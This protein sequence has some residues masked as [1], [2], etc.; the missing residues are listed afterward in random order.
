LV[1]GHVRL[2]TAIG[3][4]ALTNFL[5]ALPTVAA[6]IQSW[7]CGVNVRS[8]VWIEPLVAQ[9]LAY[10]R[11]SIPGQ[12]SSRPRVSGCLDGVL[13]NNV[14]LVVARVPFE[15]LGHVLEVSCCGLV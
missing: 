12:L 8:G 6:I 13:P 4:H 5:G 11:R 15:M 9:P 10:L 7:T 1:R 2:N 14:V 3:V